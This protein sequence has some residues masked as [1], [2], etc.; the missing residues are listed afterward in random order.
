MIDWWIP[1]DVE[2]AFEENRCVYE[3]RNFNFFNPENL[4][5]FAWDCD[6]KCYFY[7]TSLSPWKLVVCDGLSLSMYNEDPTFVD[8]GL[9]DGKIT[10]RV[11]LESPDAISVIERWVNI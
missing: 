3:L 2:K 9:E 7:D 4:L 11:E 1:S 10:P 8:D 6:A 5:F